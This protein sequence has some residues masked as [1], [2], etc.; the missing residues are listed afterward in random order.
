MI[1]YRPM[2]LEVEENLGPKARAMVDH[3]V[4]FTI[5]SI[6]E[7]PTIRATVLHLARSVENV[8]KRTTLKL[9]VSLVLVQTREIAVNIGQGLKGKRNFMK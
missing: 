9:Y 5:V 3:P 2:V 4:Q 6:V 8:A 1:Q 7:R